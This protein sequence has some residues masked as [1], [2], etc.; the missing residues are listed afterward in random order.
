MKA[1]WKA[2]LALATICLIWGTTYLALR[3][4][5]ES[6][7][8][9][10]LSGIRQSTAGLIL[11]GYFLL[12]GSRLPPWK[13]LKFHV[14][15][16][17]LM[18]FLGNGIVA[19]GEKFVPSGIAAVICSFMPVWVILI[20]TLGGH[21]KPRALTILGV[22]LGFTGIAGIFSEHL[23]DFANPDYAAGIA[24]IFAASF[25]WA[26]GTLVHKK[27]N[28]GVNPVF[29][30]GLQ[31]TSGGVLMLLS[32]PVL[33]DFSHFSPQPSSLWA[34]LY[35]TLFGSIVAYSAY[36]YALGKLPASTVS[37]YAYINPMV[38]LVLGYAVLD[39]KLNPSI[40]LFGLVT[41]A[42]IYLVNKGNKITAPQ[43]GLLPVLRARIRRSGR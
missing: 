22:L 35:L 28:A 33:D 26:L 24:I 40:G 21:E 23:A 8:P 20:T 15:A 12:N 34:L 32:S 29:S 2:Y 11:V 17:F 25:C 5:V 3:I 43:G 42:G 14:L 37:M 19:W 41:L 10:L 7:P 27:K 30:A 9:F 38:A 6:F 31:M 1:N 36:A 13:E 4:G 18:V 16:G 39:E